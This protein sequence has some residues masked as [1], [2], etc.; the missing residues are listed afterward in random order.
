LAWAGLAIA[1]AAV[2][3]QVWKAHTASAGR[4]QTHVHAGVGGD[5]WHLGAQ[6]QPELG[7]LFAEPDGGRPFHQADVA[8]RR[9]HTLIKLGTGRQVAHRYGDMIDHAVSLACFYS[10]STA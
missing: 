5:G 6:I 1:A 10:L 3:R 4:A 8:Q 9:E 7:I 2:Q